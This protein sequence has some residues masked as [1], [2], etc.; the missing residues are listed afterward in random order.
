MKQ[1][2]EFKG[3]V[4]H[5]FLNKKYWFAHFWV[6]SVISIMGLIYMGAATYMGAPPVPDFK[7]TNGELVI[8]EADIMKG[9]EIFHLRGLIDRKSTRLNSSHT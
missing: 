4:A 7:N 6:V 8:S 1:D 9:Q 5:M 2:K 3:T